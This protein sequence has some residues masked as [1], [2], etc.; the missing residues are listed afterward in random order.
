[1]LFRSDDRDF[2]RPWQ[3]RAVPNWPYSSDTLLELYALTR[4]TRCARGHWSNRQAL[5]FNFAVFEFMSGAED[6]EPDDALSLDEGQL[7]R[8]SEKPKRTRRRSMWLLLEEL[9]REK[10]SDLEITDA[11]LERAK[12]QLDTAGFKTPTGKL[13]IS[14]H[15]SYSFMNFLS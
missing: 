9:E 14:V 12:E 7:P 6:T 10:Y 1:M 4:T 2:G 5:F 11:I 8:A 15:F 3:F 13:L